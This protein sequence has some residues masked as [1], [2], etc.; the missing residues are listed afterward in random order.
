MTL[1]NYLRD[2]SLHRKFTLALLLT[3]GSALLFSMLVFTL[4][5]AMKL[6]QDAQTQ[7]ATLAR[8]IAINS[9]AALAF[10]DDGGARAILSALRAERGIVFACLG[11]VNGKELA[12]YVTAGS[13]DQACTGPASGWL[14]RRIAV[15]EPVYLEGEALGNLYVVADI[16]DTWRTLIGLLLA[17]GVLALAALMVAAR[18]GMRFRRYLTDPILELESTAARVTRDKDYSVRARKSGDDEIGRLIDSFNEMLQRIQERDVRLAQYREELEDTIEERT[19]DLRQ[20][21]VAAQS[22]SKAKSQFLA[23]MSHEIRTPMNGV[24]G[25]TDLL[26]DTELN[27]IQHRYA[28]TIRQSGE[29]LLS[30]INDI[31][32]FS[33]IEAGRMELECIAFNPGQVLYDVSGLLAQ[34]ALAKHLELISLIQP[35]VPHRVLGDPNRVRQILTNL[36]GNA[37]KFTEQGEIVVLLECLEG[38]CTTGGKAVLRFSVRDTGIGIPED[39][40]GRVFKSFSQA[41]SSHARRFGGTGL[42]LA[43]ARE[44]SYMMDGE[45]GVESKLGQ[46]STFWFTLRA[47]IVDESMHAGEDARYQGLRALLVD[48][49]ATNLEVIGHYL[50]GLGIDVDTATG[51]GEA[52]RRMREAKQ[53]DL[54]YHLVLIDMSMPDVDGL[55]IA[56]QIR[57]DASLRETALVLLTSLAEAGLERRARE[58]GFDYVSHKPVRQSELPEI[59]GAAL[60]RS[61]GVETGT[62]QDK[63]V[64]TVRGTRVLLV[65]DNVTNQE[66]A[67][68]LLELIGCVVTLAENG[69]RAVQAM[70][71]GKFDIVLMD[72]QM[73]EMDGYEATR[74][75]RASEGQDERTP[76]IAMTANVMKGDREACLASGMDDFLPKPYRQADL[77]SILARWSKSNKARG[78]EVAP[79]RVAREADTAQGGTKALDESVLDELRARFGAQAAPLLGN[80]T[81]VYIENTEKLLDTMATALSEGNATSLFHAAHTVKS[82]S[83]NLGAMR[84]SSVSREIEEAARAGRLDGLD[85]RMVEARSAYAGA[86]EALMAVVEEKPE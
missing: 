8:A 63:D 54:A 77:M 39:A 18:L 38:G 82:S 11:Q 85:A 79:P 44:L 7:V 51:A 50:G 22:A 33:K 13:G 30:I 14:A 15:N 48:D 56:R 31:L 1:A 71:S 76:I 64:D 62:A 75:I 40:L 34:R 19:A 21:M 24:L 9:Q 70:R 3:A 23:T 52:M 2:L 67:K 73:P 53:R 36:V 55:E 4:G 20:A 60:H 69:R 28:Q 42:G 5:A 25:M 78:Q 74:Q 43:I 86:C 58:A 10:S 35:G 12:R 32:D 29:A 46:G 57:R 6:R 72:C 81:R 45:V 84:L 65:E 66:L 27:P 49:N 61:P 83:A 68:S 41:D 16:S 17:F 47:D 26:L 80:L 37:V 59:I